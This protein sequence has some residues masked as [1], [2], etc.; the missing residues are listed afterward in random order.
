MPGFGSLKS[1]PG[2]F[3]EQMKMPDAP[4]RS[5]KVM[6]IAAISLL[7]L[8]LSHHLF[9]REPVPGEGNGATAPHP[10][11]PSLTAATAGSSAGLPSRAAPRHAVPATGGVTAPLGEHVRQWIAALE[12]GEPLRLRVGF[13]EMQ[14][15]RLL[16]RPR[17]L[18]AGSFQM[19]LGTQGAVL[20]AAVRSYE[21]RILAH[22]GAS[23]ATFAPGTATVVV[24]DNALAA[25]I[26]EDSGA[27]TY[28]RTNPATGRLEARMQL[29][30]E[31][32]LACVKR[33]G[34]AFTL[35]TENGLGFGGAALWAD[36]VPASMHCDG[37]VPAAMTGMDPV[38]GELDKYVNRIPESPAYAASLK[39]ALLLVVL[40]KSATGPGTDTNLASRA[41]LYLATISNVAAVYENQL[42]VRLLLSELI[43]IPDAPGFADVTISNEL[44]DFRS[45]MRRNR[46]RSSHGWTLAT[47]FGAGLTDNVLGVAYVG[48]LGSDNAVS[49]CD[50]SGIWDVLAHEMGHNFGSEH[51]VGGIM[52][53]SSLGGKVRTFFTDV[54][55]GDTSA[56]AIYR[57]AASRLPGNAVLRDAEQIPFAESDSAST[58]PNT[59]VV[60]SPLEND[61]TSVRNGAVN[62][63]SV[64]ELSTVSPA[65]AGEVELVGN[66][67]RFSP[68]DGFQG[69]AWF[70]YALRGSVGNGG[71]GWL[72]KG[73][74]G[75]RV[76]SDPEPRRIVLPPGGSYSFVHGA[77]TN[78]GAIT[79]PAMARVDVS[80]D[81]PRLIIIR[82]NVDASGTDTFRISTRS[83]TYSIVY[84]ESS[85]RTR[86]DNFVLDPR[87]ER[88]EF[89][90]LV[91]DEAAG[92]RWLQDVRPVAGV[93]T[94]GADPA[95]K[96]LFGTTFRLVSAQ[97][98]TPELGSIVLPT[99]TVVIDGS[100]TP[101]PRGSILFMPKDGSSGTARIEYRVQDAAGR[102]ATGSAEIRLVPVRTE[103]LIADDA[104]VTVLVPES[105]EGESEWMIPEF[106]D[107]TWQSGEAGVGYERGTG[108]ES[109]IRTSVEGSMFNAGTSVYIRTRFEV[110]DPLRFAL[111]TLRM[112][113]DD[114]F[115]AYLNGVEIARANAQGSSPLAWDSGASAA[116]SDSEAVEFVS[117]DITSHIGDLRNG[118]NVLAVHGLNQGSSSSDLLIAPELEGVIVGEGAEIIAPRF[119]EIAI[120]EGTG[121][122]ASGRA[123]ATEGARVRWVV[124]SAPEG[125]V[126]AFG[127]TGAE[128][129][130]VAMQFSH[131]GEYRL[132]FTASE[133]DGGNE[134]E[135]SLRILVG[136]APGQLPRGV[137]ASIDAGGLVSAGLGTRLVAEV[138]APAAGVEWQ[139][140]RGPGT[141]VISSPRQQSTEVIASASGTYVLR[142]VMDSGRIQ[143]FREVTWQA[144]DAPVVIASAATFVG[145][146]SATLSGYL[147]G[148]GKDAFAT[149]FL[150]TADGGAEP[151]RWEAAFPATI[152]ASGRTETG[153]DGLMADTP[154]SFR[155]AVTSGNGQIW[156]ASGSFRTQPFEPYTQILL[157]ENAGGAVFVPPT[158]AAADAIPLWR[159]GAF[160]DS[161][162]TT[163]VTGF[164]YDTS[165]TFA[166]FVA[167]DITDVMFNIGTSLFVRVPFFSEL[168]PQRIDNL[169]LRM[170]YDDAFVAYLNG[171]EIARSANAPEGEPA[172]NAVPQVRRDNAQA[173]QF[174][175]YDASPGLGSLRE[176]DNLLA[177]HGINLMLDSRDMLIAP[178]I[179]AGT[180]SSNYLRWVESRGLTG[181]A[182]GVTADG[183]N[184]GLANLQEFAFGLDPRVR[185]DPAA[186][187][188][189]MHRQ[190]ASATAGVA[191][192]FT[193]R[194]DA[195]A[196]GIAYILEQSGDL[197][198]WDMIALADDAVEALPGPEGKPALTERVSVALP[199]VRASFLRLRVQ[200]RQ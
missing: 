43:M 27:I 196:A 140:I 123:L 151:A 152:D 170:R 40:D 88:L 16:F 197:E 13:G 113:Y 93:G 70:S 65:G 174:E 44:G 74:V 145:D 100:R 24:M 173:V 119:D 42:G 191:V 183:D 175:E 168:A 171:V 125:S 148:T 164:G 68:A 57:H 139:L 136:G 83:A 32:E 150:G 138:E 75:V 157:A 20:A 66:A 135:D 193:R 25:V 31:V 71:L 187:L 98:L 80:R 194:R 190:S 182:A 49:M 3:S 36:A 6:R 167:T 89:F 35:E 149:F 172:W 87:A 104:P 169:T 95:G 99:H 124:D 108:Y 186:V 1:E 176:G 147:A 92:E 8:L 109:L 128:A 132:R 77:A 177:I 185:D 195:A 67:V 56:A 72:H 198:H 38:T 19:A 181:A 180:R 156:S 114:G 86:P 127:G 55:P 7:M 141:A 26:R 118:T 160:D 96:A 94:P 130:D 131:P 12:T 60:I 53:A 192:E 17:P 166:E 159:E 106:D 62:A 46:Q 22:P 2:V 129:E 121:L 115:V 34:G 48:S 4:S 61:A 52:N 122:L 105:G 162:W 58:A 81:D 161:G 103:L 5:Q 143:T 51:S 144:G 133:P 158:S 30:G 165:G 188:P 91:N 50:T 73:D 116:H 112:R 29:P 37:S 120:A 59:A 126:V 64:E 117:F 199:P 85:P 79:Q 23:R 134:T 69:T 82:A 107:R 21:G 90:P 28:L 200:L 153:A 163:G 110:P 111:L 9:Q 155:I 179:V 76:G 11:T 14:G 146:T 45:W 137:D 18:F 39:D 101:V 10:G 33:S 184:D 178:E 47:K 41:S 189:A 63:L 84:D 15:W 154:Y 97:L 142:L 102:Q 54:A 78:N